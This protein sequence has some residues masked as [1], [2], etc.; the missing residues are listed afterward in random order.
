MGNV[1][2]G[3]VLFDLGSGDGRILTM[4]SKE[5]GAK[6]VGIEI[7]PFLIL[8]TKIKTVFS[9]LSGKVDVIWGNFFNQ[10][11]AKA[12][13]VTLYLLQGTNQKLK[14]KL[15]KELQPGTR[16]VSHVFTFDGWEPEK[17]DLDWKIYMYRIDDK[18]N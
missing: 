2:P 5:F 9:G 6:A 10:N 15:E 13:V 17:V 7:N 11:L 12:N 1:G 18:K 16:I 4:A 8:W 14:P 3:D